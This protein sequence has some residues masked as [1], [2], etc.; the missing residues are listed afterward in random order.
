MSF[1]PGP[2]CIGTFGAG[3]AKASGIGSYKPYACR[4][5]SSKVATLS[6]VAA[7]I[8]SQS[9]K[10]SSVRGPEKGYDPGKNV[11]GRKR[12]V[13]VDTQGY[14]LA[15]KVLAASWSEELGAKRLLEPLRD[16]LPRVRVL[17]GDSH[18]AGSLIDWVRL[19]LGWT[20][21]TVRRRKAPARGLL[22]PI[23]EEPEWEKLFPSG[24][25][26][27]P[28]RWIVERTLAWITQ[29]RRLCRDHEGLPQSSEAFITIAMSR[30]MLSQ[31]VP[32]FP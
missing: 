7:I 27:L 24:F 28:R 19:H 17:F 20:I 26:P 6:E 12:Q 5:V 1:R 9:I 31:L 10:T 29:W 13:L 30:L 4:S 22:V 25:Q 16:C 21:Q 18:Y 2:P 11:W 32:P 15:V 3:T 23:G 14:L 8:D